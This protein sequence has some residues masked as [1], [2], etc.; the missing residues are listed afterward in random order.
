VRHAL[1]VERAG[2]AAEQGQRD[3]RHII[4]P[5]GLDDR[6]AGPQAPGQPV[7]IA[8]H[9]V[10]KAHKGLS[11]RDADLE[12]HRD[13]G[14]T[15][16]RHRHHMLRT[17]DLRQHLLGRPGHHLLHIPGAG[18]GKGD[19]HIGHR[20]IDLGLLFAWRDEHGERAQ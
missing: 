2:M 11:A 17:G 10:M 6:G 3:D 14:Q 8:V 12:L 7:G 5:L 4:D 13:D 18:A 19:Q 9:R 20:H 1:Q 15:R 16:A